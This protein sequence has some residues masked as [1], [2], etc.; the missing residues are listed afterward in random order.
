MIFSSIQNALDTMQPAEQHGFRQCK[1]LGK[2]VVRANTVIDRFL[3]ICVLVWVVRLDLSK[4]FDKVSW[5]Q[6]WNAL[7]A[8]G[9]SRQL[10]RIIQCLFGQQT[11][12]VQSGSGHSTAFATGAG[13]RQE[14]VLSSCL[15]W[16]MHKWIEN[17]W[18]QRVRG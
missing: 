8:H 11:G 4:P 15:P 5:I 13:V 2:H 1:R 7:T 16:A 14:C 17:M 6:P 3:A 10:V 12:C 18:K 9:D